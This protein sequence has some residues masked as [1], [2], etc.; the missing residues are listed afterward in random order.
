MFH[1]DPVSFH[2]SRSLGTFNLF[3]TDSDIDSSGQPFELGVRLFLVARFLSDD[4]DLFANWSISLSNDLS[5][6]EGY[7]VRTETYVRGYLS[8][9]IIS[10]NTIV[11]ETVI[12][13]TIKGYGSSGS[14]EF[15]YPADGPF[16]ILPGMAIT[17]EQRLY[18]GPDTSTVPTPN[19]LL[20]FSSALI[21]LV[22]IARRKNAVT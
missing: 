7:V 2:T 9:A 15:V 20:L 21:G 6:P 13:D 17:V 22:G 14:G 5:L 18:I 8:E 19:S 12:Y 11:G 1:D 16:G 10:G 4:Y 3:A